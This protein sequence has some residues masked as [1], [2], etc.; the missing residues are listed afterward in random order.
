MNL[1]NIKKTLN[2]DVGVLGRR[3][4]RKTKVAVNKNNTERLSRKKVL[5]SQARNNYLDKKT[6]ANNAS[7][8]KKFYKGEDTKERAA[9]YRN[10]QHRKNHVPAKRRVNVSKGRVLDYGID[11]MQ[12][13]Q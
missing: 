7:M 5:V 6:A 2:T 8:T 9:N 1:S 4:V 3:L 12:R 13:F 11:R 10:D